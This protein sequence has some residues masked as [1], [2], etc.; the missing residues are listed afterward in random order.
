MSG[1]VC[2][3]PQTAWIKNE[4][5]RNNVLFGQAYDES[6]YE[7]TIHVCA[8]QS[9]IDML[10][11]G[12]DCEI[13][14]KGINLSGGQK[15]R[16][17]IARAVYSDADVFLFDDPLSAVDIHVGKHIFSE[18]ITGVLSGKTRVL[19]THQLYCLQGADLI[20]CMKDGKISEMGTY[21]E[22]NAAGLDFAELIAT[23]GDGNEDEQNN[24]E[25]DQKEEK[26]QKKKKQANKTSNEKN[27]DKNG[28]LIGAEER[29]TGS[30]DRQVYLKYFRD[31][32]LFVSFGIVLFPA[33]TQACSIGSNYWLS[34]WGDQVAL[35]EPPHSQNWFMVRYFVL[36]ITAGFTTF[37]GAL[38]LAWGCINAARRI[39]N[40]TLRSVFRAPVSF[41]DTTPAGRILNRFSKDQA[42]IDSTLP[43]SISSLIG[44]LMSVSGVIILILVA[45]PF[46]LLCV[47]PLGV[48]YFYTS[49]YYLRTSRELKRIDS[50]TNSPIYSHFSET[51]SGVSTIRAYSRQDAFIEEN[52]QRLDKNLRAYLPSVSVNRWL[53]QRLEFVGTCTLTTA[54]LF[55]VFTRN[56]VEP[57]LIGL[58]LTYAL[59]MA[60]ALNWMIRMSTETETQMNAIER[61]SHYT[62]IAQ[63]APRRLPNDPDSSWPREGR[64]EF[65]SMVM[66]Y[67]EDLD[68]VIKGLS[69]VVY[70][71]EKIGIVGRTGAGKSSLIQALFRIVEL[72]SGSIEVDGVDIAEI[73][74]ERLRIEMAII[75]QD[76]MLFSGTIRS[77]LDPF[78]EASDHEI[79]QSLERVHLNST[80]S[81]M[82]DGID[83]EVTENGENFSV[84]QRQ[85]L[86][87]ARALLR[88]TKVIVM[89][90]ATSACDVETDHLIQQTI[91]EQCSDSTVITIAHRLNTIIDYDRIMVL[92]EGQ[93]MEFDTPSTLLADNESLFSAMVGSSKKLRDIVSQMNTDDHAT[94][95]A[96]VQNL[97]AN[98]SSSSSDILDQSDID[99]L[100]DGV[101]QTKQ[102]LI[103]LH[104][105]S[106]S[107]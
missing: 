15:Q 26:K 79:W 3:V 25:S 24:S 77:N 60:G 13:G 103:D 91:R 83:S 61:M 11:G 37:F 17:S 75:P 36:S 51:L 5:L 29:D 6:K 39:H 27:D 80:I 69:A 78:G 93:L 106:S 81:H 56:S 55:A 64:I 65:K 10:V 40:R 35:E 100:L 50:I 57:G 52:E 2:Y 49:A 71:R 58:A 92:Q 107:D 38:L 53:G 30:V 62:N 43:Q 18:C 28:K 89:D 44:C 82:T 1:R 66:R 46:F 47:I 19:V 68:P 102:A 104:D 23:H 74:L 45:S 21:E 7:E 31:I 12:N 48:L 9:D 54:A 73:G 95:S 85:L 16:I 88:R 20:V 99:D 42:A 84:G 22:L 59:S 8:L 63:E 87:L 70:P 72:S 76:P 105:F 98:I 94:S 34:Y 41:F 90:E 33:L 86:C 67:R 101:D 4:T 14:E 32:G 97:I 96:S